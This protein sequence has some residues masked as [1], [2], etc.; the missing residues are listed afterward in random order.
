MLNIYLLLQQGEGEKK[1]G[2][3]E[4]EGVYDFEGGEEEFEEEEL[5]EDKVAG[6]KLFKRPQAV[7]DRVGQRL[8]GLNCCT[9]LLDSTD[10]LSCCT[11]IL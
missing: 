3:E 6:V 5:G 8:A 1:E 10:V 7:G 4:L 11:E 9:E 2:E